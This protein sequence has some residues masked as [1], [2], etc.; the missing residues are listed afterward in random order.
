MKFVLNTGIFRNESGEKLFEI[1][2]ITSWEEQDR[3]G[4]IT[5]YRKTSHY[6]INNGDL[7]IEFDGYCL[8]DSQNKMKI[9]PTGTISI[10]KI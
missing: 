2:E 9:Q 5:K 6:V 8:K 1:G 10:E 7:I 4:N 3:Y